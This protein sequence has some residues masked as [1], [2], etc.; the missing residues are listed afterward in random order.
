MPE[1]LL[2][3]IL[4]TC[5]HQFSWPRRSDD[6]DYYQV[7]LE[8]GVKYRYDWHSM[9]RTARLDD[10]EASSSAL[11]R[12]PMRKCS[13]KNGWHPRERRLRT[14]VP[15]Q[16]REKGMT[17]EWRTARSEN[18]SRSG[19]LFSL[20]GELLPVGSDIELVFLMPAEICGTEPADVLCQAR[21]VRVSEPGRHQ[22]AKIA[23]AIS[24]YVFLPKARVG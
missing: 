10:K 1:T 22:P 21:V 15:V 16:F 20:E 5:R 24:D 4:F 17:G 19:L 8:C 18:I 2:E 9:R 14:H 3:R 6:G 13:G 11:G 7:C 12:K 23:A